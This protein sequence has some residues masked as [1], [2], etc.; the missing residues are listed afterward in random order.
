LEP[1]ETR[2]LFQSLVVPKLLVRAKETVAGRRQQVPRVPPAAANAALQTWFRVEH[3]VAGW[4]PFGGSLLAVAGP[5]RS[6]RST[7]PAR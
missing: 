5:S 4:L 2:Y 1:L 3:A 6:G 7:D